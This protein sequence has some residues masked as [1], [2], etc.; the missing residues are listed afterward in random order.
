MENPWKAYSKVNPQREDG[1]RRINSDIWQALVR[2]DIT[3]SAYKVVLHVIDRSWG[4]DKLEVTIGYTSFIK[5]T[6]LTKVSIRN[7]AREAE[8]KRLL[9]IKPGN[10]NQAATYLF[11]K[12][13][14]TWT[15]LPVI[16]INTGKTNNTRPG[17]ANSTTPGIPLTSKVSLPTES[18]IKRK[19]GNIYT[20]NNKKEN[21]GSTKYFS[22]KYGHM[23]RK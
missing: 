8:R 14:D 2:A 21:T 11:N 7:G 9:V 6:G 15:C 16:E 23:V 3:A 19:K 10:F 18:I 1:H 12:H 4:Y 20:E 5:A 13:Y 17:I 22:G